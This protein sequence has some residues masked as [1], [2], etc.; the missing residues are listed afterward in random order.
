ME[1]NRLPYYIKIDKNKDGIPVIHVRRFRVQFLL[2]LILVLALIPAL[3]YLILL[4][5]FHLLAFLGLGIFIALAFISFPTIFV[6]L[7]YCLQFFVNTTSI[8]LNPDKI[9][10]ITYPL[11]W[12]NGLYI[13]ASR[14]LSVT[15]TQTHDLNNKP[16]KSLVVNLDSGGMISLADNLTDPE[17]S[18]YLSDFIRNYYGLDEKPKNQSNENN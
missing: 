11:T 8:H 6:L 7:G 15:S 12:E 18:N 9:Y 5:S 16:T 1:K 14:I 2:P 10:K 4:T 3:P 17:V 13:Q